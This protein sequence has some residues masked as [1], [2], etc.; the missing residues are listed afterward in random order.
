MKAII[1]D[2]MG[3]QVLFEE[4]IF[5]EGKNTIE[6]DFTGYHSG[7]Y[8]IK[9]IDKNGKFPSTLNSRN[10]EYVVPY[11]LVRS[12]KYLNE[13]NYLVNII[14][15]DFRKNDNIYNSYDDRYHSH[16]LFSSLVR[17]IPFLK[18]LKNGEA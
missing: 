7:V 14:F 2:N 18:N 8:Y 12:A 6:L 9:V 3:K 10:T 16:Y 13:A 1:Y 11:G 15:K 17:S 5:F 4:A